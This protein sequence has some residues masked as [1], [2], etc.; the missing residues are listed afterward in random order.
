[1]PLHQTFPLQPGGAAVE[2]AAYLGDQAGLCI[3]DRTGWPRFGVKGPGS[4]DWFESIGIALPRPNMLAERT[5][6]TVLRLG[7]NDITVLAA[8]QS[9]AEVLQLVTAW[10]AAAEPK[11]YSS[12]RDEAWAWLH[13]DGPALE[14]TLAACCA[15]DLRPAH[16]AADQ[17]AQTR[18]AHVDAVVLRRESGVDVL[19][20]ISTSGTVLKTI[21]EV[22]SHA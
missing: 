9:S 16:F 22:G 15:V 17:I 6:M 11:G 18:F 3:A 10:Q 14:D 20:D 2:F 1:M 21:R 7:Q 5:D 12:W 13:L 19:F 8:C 4:A